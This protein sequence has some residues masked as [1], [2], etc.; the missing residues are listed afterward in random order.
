MSV[1]IV[2]DSAAALPAELAAAHGI[3]VVPMMITVD[4]RSGHDGDMSIEAIVA[5]SEVETAGPSPGDFAEAIER[6][7][8]PDG[9]L[10]LTLASS[11]SS[12]C[13]S[14]SL[15]ASGFAGHAR[16]RRHADRGRRAGT[17]GARGR[18]GRR[19]RRLARRSGTEW[20]ET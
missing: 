4:G 7:M 9:V 3:T 6:V 10:V 17:G 12:T 11:M 20:P 19:G 14:A 13:E 2:T 18:T 1:A 8:T 16:V 5:A 15:G